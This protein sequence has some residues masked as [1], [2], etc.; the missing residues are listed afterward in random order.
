MLDVGGLV[1]FNFCVL[2]VIIYIFYVSY[3]FDILKE[4]ERER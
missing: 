1:K 4:R 2:S 3:L